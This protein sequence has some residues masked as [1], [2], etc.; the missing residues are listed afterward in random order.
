[1]EATIPAKYKMNLT[2]EDKLKYQKLMRDGRL[3]LT[4]QGIYD[5]GMMSVLKKARCSVDKA[6][7][8]C[9]LGGE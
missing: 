9:T 3:E 6:N 5:A 1:L 2:A 7:F 4:K 8:E